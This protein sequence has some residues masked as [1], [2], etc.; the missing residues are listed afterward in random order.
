MI[1]KVNHLYFNNITNILFFKLFGR[2]K[3]AATIKDIAK[4]IGVSV[5]TVSRALKDKPEISEETKALV[6]TT[7]PTL[8]L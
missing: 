6:R 4:S 2:M 8:W 1:I 5:S 3:K 7:A